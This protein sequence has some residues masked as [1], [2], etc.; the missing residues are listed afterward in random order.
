MSEAHRIVSNMSRNPYYNG[1]TTPKVVDEIC[2]NFSTFLYCNG[3]GRNM[4]FTPITENTIAFKTVS[5]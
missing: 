3:H 5:F 1:T 4:V 2:E